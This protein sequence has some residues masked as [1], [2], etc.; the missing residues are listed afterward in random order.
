MPTT[1]LSELPGKILVLESYNSIMGSF[2]FQ[3]FVDNNEEYQQYIA[4]YETEED[5]DSSVMVVVSE[6]TQDTQVVVYL[7]NQNFQKDLSEV[8]GFN[9][10]ERT[11]EADLENI[12]FSGIDDFIPPKEN[13]NFSYDFKFIKNSGNYIFSDLNLAK[14]V[15]ADVATT[16]TTD[17]TTSGGSTGTRYA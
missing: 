3:A 9:Y 15:A 10:N 5:P 12:I 8:Y 17:R 6:L 11:T 4:N 1:T 13:F 16:I 2:I 14:R 7:A